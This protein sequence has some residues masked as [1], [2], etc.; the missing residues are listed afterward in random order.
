[1]KLFGT[2]AATCA[3]AC[4]AAGYGA[5]QASLWYALPGP[6]RLP[7]AV[8]KRLH[9]DAVSVIKSQEMTDQLLAQGAEPVANT[10]QELDGFMHG[11][12]ERWIKLI[13]QAQ[14]RAD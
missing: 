10:P 2:N 8:V 12:I 9:D 1:M 14:I 4:S 13:R 6:A 3:A 5:Y 7:P 11:E